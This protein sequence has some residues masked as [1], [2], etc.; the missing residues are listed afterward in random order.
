MLRPFGCAQDRPTPST[1]CFD[2][3]Q[4][5]SHEYIGYAQCGVLRLR[6]ARVFTNNHVLSNAEG[7]KD[8]TG[9]DVG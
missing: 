2:K 7:L 6:S 3:A 4:H 8:R 5:K 9:G 1:A